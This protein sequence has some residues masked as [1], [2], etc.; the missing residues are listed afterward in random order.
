[1]PT[2]QRNHLHQ[3]PRELIKAIIEATTNQDDLC[4]PCADSFIVLLEA[5]QKL[6]R[7][8]LG[9]DFDLS[10]YSKIHQKNT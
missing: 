10:G 7:E 2:N 5:C 6:G 1:L 9:C 3:K 8:F 4:S